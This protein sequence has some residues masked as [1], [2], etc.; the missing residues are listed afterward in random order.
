MRGAKLDNR[1]PNV[2]A[3]GYVDWLDYGHV[4]K[5]EQWPTKQIRIRWDRW[6]Y[7]E[8][9]GSERDLRSVDILPYFYW[10]VAS[11]GSGQSWKNHYLI[12]YSVRRIISRV[13]GRSIT[14]SLSWVI[15]TSV[16]SG[17]WKS[18][19]SC[20]ASLSSLSLPAIRP[21][22]LMFLITSNCLRQG[23]AA[24][25]TVWHMRR[26]SLATSESWRV[27]NCAYEFG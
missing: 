4:Q 6:K 24:R 19:K 15:S 3:Q 11:A 2:R 20:F 25:S 13:I 23:F 27:S 16:I 1:C 21:S 10:L 12:S 7:C 17:N 14:V 18:Q 8:R 5:S 26:R 22:H 9:N